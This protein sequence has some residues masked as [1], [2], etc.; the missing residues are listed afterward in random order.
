MRTIYEF[1]SAKPWLDRKT[2]FHC[3][4]VGMLGDNESRL[5]YH[6][7][8]QVFAGRG[9][10][11]DAGS[12]LGKSAYFLAK[13]LR[14]NPVYKTDAHRI[15]CFDNFLVNEP[16]TVQFI[17]ANL[18]LT[19]A[20]GDS[21][22]AIF[23]RQVAPVRDALDVFE[24]DF[25]TIDWPSQP[26][27]ILMVDIA[28]AESLGRRVAELFYTKLIP[29]VSVVIHQDYHHPWL[30]HVHVV[31]EYLAD[32]FDLVIPEADDSAV[33]FYKKQAP[34]EMI[35]R[36]IAYD[37]TAEE[38]LELMNRAIERLPRDHRHFVELA[39][40]IMRLNDGPL[41]EL[42]AELID[43]EGSAKEI[44]G[45]RATT[46]LQQALEVRTTV[47]EMQGWRCIAAQDHARALDLAIGVLRHRRNTHNL[48]MQ[49]V[50]YIGLGLHH[51]AEKSLR[52][53]LQENPRSGYAYVELA[54]VLYHKQQFEKAEDL[55]F[56]A[57]ADK[58]AGFAALSDYVDMLA[59]ILNRQWNAAAEEA[60]LRRLR[61]IVGTDE[62]EVQVL[63]AILAAVRQQ[64]EEARKALEA[65]RTLGAEQRRL[66]AVAASFRIS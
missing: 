20:V 51:N 8:E 7:T 33:F 55:I 19:V 36:A 43:L 40:V 17:K 1:A 5:F 48:T 59:M 22:R 10:I 52:A 31:M 49:G 4:P 47:E 25:H 24:G 30:P 41:D 42:R 45:D 16:N 66:A 64:P 15:Q 61:A 54:R 29:N 46:F 39:R 21:T 60:S 62:P 13:G 27:E 2:T 63:T 26:I 12:F 35:A 3:T 58:T 23:D 53:A 34:P 18:D 37:F 65:A 38:K 11:I 56:D 14:Q 57:I 32:C 28:K 44:L 6:L 9:T 50:A